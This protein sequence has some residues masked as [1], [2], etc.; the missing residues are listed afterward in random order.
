MH[1][2]KSA[3]SL[4]P[5][6]R[7]RGWCRV[8]GPYIGALL[9]CLILVQLVAFEQVRLALM[10]VLL[11]LFVGLIRLQPR[12]GLVVVLAYL[13]VF[14]DIR[15]ALIP[16]VGWAGQDPL[17]LI[18]P[19]AVALLLVSPLVRGQI[20]LDTR[21][22]RWV[23]G[24]M[25]VMVI[26]MFNPKQGGLAV[27]VAG[28]LFYIVPLL[29]FWAGRAYGNTTL[30]KTNFY[31]VVVPL[32]SVAAMLG[33]YQALI[34]LLPYQ[35]AWVDL[36]GYTALS[37]GGQTRSFSFFTSAAEYAHYMGVA[38]VLIWAGVLMRYRTVY[39]LLL[40]LFGWGILLAGTRTVV[41]VSLFACSVL[42]AVQG[43]SRSVWL[44]RLV[45]ALLLGAVAL[46][47]SL[48][49]VGEVDLGGS[50]GAALQHQVQGLTT[51][52][53]STVG[54]HLS[55][56]VGGI[57]EGFRTPL[58]YG[59]G[60]TTDAASKFGGGSWGTERD[61][62]NVFVSLGVVGGLIYGIII[63]MVYLRTVL[64]WLQTRNLVSL[65]VLGLL[66]TELGLWLNGNHY[67]ITALVWFCI[68]SI[69]R[70]VQEGALNEARAFIP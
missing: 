34:G 49:Q 57:R 70:I 24:L 54:T 53:E 67:A 47:W 46:V 32:A 44:P 61:L 9:L 64:Y 52:G 45:L 50:A 14:G 22:S 35:Q 1:V 37:L 16:L 25:L 5:L 55:L 10:L 65:A 69:D 8:I 11:V 36:G 21:L 17:L 40:P 58:G 68:G 29:W 12:F 48:S 63:A 13:A 59:L 2:L 23:A 66:T 3:L 28:A 30:L 51:P 60:A 31:N 62:S 7:A 6:R 38:F 33:I 41:V 43:R 20:R 4:Q 15:R 19:I 56:F 18:G 42:W 39:I 27:G 26:Q